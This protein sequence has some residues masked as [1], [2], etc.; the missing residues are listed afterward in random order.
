MFSIDVV[1]LACLMIVGGF[2]LAGCS[3]YT[4][5]HRDGDGAIGYA[6]LSLAFFGAT[7][8]VVFGFLH[9]FAGK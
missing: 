7:L 5:F 8:G 9:T 3:V 2:S 4:S 1:I 6:F